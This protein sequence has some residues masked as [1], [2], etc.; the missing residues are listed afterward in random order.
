ME[1]LQEN[2]EGTRRRGTPARTTRHRSRIWPQVSGSCQRL[3]RSVRTHRAVGQRVAECVA[4]AGGPSGMGRVMRAH[5]QPATD[6]VGP[7]M[8][9][10]WCRSPHSLPQRPLAP[11]AGGLER[12]AMN[13]A[14]NLI[15][16]SQAFPD[17]PVV[18]LDETVLS[19]A[20]LDE[21]S[22]RVAGLLR[23][24]GLRAGDRVAVMLPNVPTFAVIYY[25]VLR[26]GG[27]V[28]PMNPLLK[29]REVA[30]YLDDSG[31]RLIF[32]GPDSAEAVQAG[33][34][35]TGADAVIVDE[36]FAC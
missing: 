9:G 26:A 12:S 15:R 3:P 22:A 32:A 35:R 31:A 30:Y 36:G 34:V 17:R 18:R 1:T 16:T 20:D 27:I 28:V 23:E 25:G 14:Y 13:L 5:S 21:G 24:C 2:E 19:Y 33:V 4:A 8:A 11:P 7:H 10:S 6:C 29:A